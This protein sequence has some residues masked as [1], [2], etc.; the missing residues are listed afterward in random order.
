MKMMSVASGSSGNST[1]I[2]SDTTSILLDA[3]ISAKAIERGLLE[4][5]V[6]IRDVDAILVTHEHYDHIKGIGVLSRK[7]NIPIL[8]TYGTADGIMQCKSLGTFDYNL[9]SSFQAGDSFMVGD[10]QV[11]THPISHDAFEPVCYSFEKDGKK[12][13][14][15]TD[16]GIYDD[17]IIDFLS[18]SDAMIIEAN[19]DIRM[20]E[21][22]DYPYYLKKRIL[23]KLGHL[24]N[25]AGGKLIRAL[26]N[27][28]LKFVGLGHLSEKNNYPEL[29]Y[30]AV[31]LELAGN[32]FFDDVRE[33][34]LS[35][36]P[37][38]NPGDLIEV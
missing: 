25:E 35:V 36:A 26:L 34:N 27:D 15:A 3:G 38:Y 7:Y 20:L 32:F 5:D 24:S 10:I 31:K 16:L 23:G 11:K 6:S 22:G 17:M 29:A 19:H 2:G 1:Y 21:A 18:E 8:C 13:S 14:V 4:A 33:I 12:V 37:R 30:E 28:H 9:I